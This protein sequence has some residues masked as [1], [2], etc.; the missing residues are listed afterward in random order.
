MEHVPGVS[1]LFSYQTLI[2]YAWKLV[3]ELRGQSASRFFMKP[4]SKVNGN[5]PGAPW[6]N[7][8]TLSWPGW[9]AGLAWPC[10]L[11]GLPGLGWAGWLGWLAGLAGLAGLASL[12]RKQE[13]LSKTKKNHSK[14]K[15]T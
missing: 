1:F 3:R 9:L 2:K 13:N 8:L 10:W 12:V 7:S 4:S 14:T 6:T 5:T 15:K 11:A